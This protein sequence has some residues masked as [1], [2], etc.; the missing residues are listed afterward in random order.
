MSVTLRSATHIVTSTND[1][2]MGSLRQIVNISNPGDSIVFDQATNGSPIVLSTGEILILHDLFIIGN[3]AA[4]TQI[5]GQS[6]QRIF[7]VFNT[8]FT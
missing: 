5:E 6:S 8:S 1:A 7:N 3:G 4:Q 2:G